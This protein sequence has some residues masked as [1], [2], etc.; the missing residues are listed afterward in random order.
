MQLVTDGL[1]CGAVL[2]VPPLPS[3]RAL[4][5]SRAAAL[6]RLTALKAPHLRWVS[7]AGCPELRDVIF[8]CQKLVC[9]GTDRPRREDVRV[10]SRCYCP[11]MCCR[12]SNLGT[13]G[14]LRETGSP[15][16]DG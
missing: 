2:D 9:I 14:V 7:L 5:I 13:D 16:G 11:M 10:T 3:L 12:T 1:K 15:E 4:T 6:V 8:D